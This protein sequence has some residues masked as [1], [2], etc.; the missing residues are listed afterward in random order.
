MVKYNNIEYPYSRVRYML[1]MWSIP[2]KGLKF[3]L[4]NSTLRGESNF[5]C[6]SEKELSNK[7][8]IIAF[9]LWDLCK[10]DIDLNK[11]NLSW[12]GGLS[13]YAGCTWNYYFELPKI[14]LEILQEALN[15]YYPY[16]NFKVMT[17]LIKFNFTDEANTPEFRKN[18]VSLWKIEGKL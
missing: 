13:H 9:I 2:D 3:R 12:L 8:F 4:T 1:D 11:H 15:K 5:R 6:F 14:N 17:N 18:L 7:S 10:N 16:V